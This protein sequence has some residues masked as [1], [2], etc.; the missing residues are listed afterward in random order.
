VWWAV[1][2]VRTVGY[3]DNY[4]Q[5]NGGRIIAIVVMFVGIGFVAI[6]TAAAAER[7][8][9][10]RRTDEAAIEDRLDE[11]ARRLEAIERRK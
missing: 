7:F 5:T 6:L 10:E 2:T 9:R 8:M 11:I 3:G 4:P 1:T